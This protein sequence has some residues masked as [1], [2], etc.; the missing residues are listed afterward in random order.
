VEFAGN[1][2]A[3]LDAGH[4]KV[5]VAVPVP[6]I[7]VLL[8]RDTGGTYQFRQTVVYATQPASEEDWRSSNRGVLTVPVK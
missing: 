7:D 2:R 6:L 3:V 8:Q 4:T 1:T 5:D